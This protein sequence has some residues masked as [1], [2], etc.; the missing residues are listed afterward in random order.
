MHTKDHNMD[1]II[2]PILQ[3]KKNLKSKKVNLPGI[4]QLWWKEKF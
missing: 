1:V 2:T 3:T 4:I